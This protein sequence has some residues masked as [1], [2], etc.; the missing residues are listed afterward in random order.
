M[1][2]VYRP[3]QRPVSL[4][5]PRAA[6]THWLMQPHRQIHP[7]E[8]EAAFGGAGGP[9]TAVAEALVGGGGVGADRA[10]VELGVVDGVGLV[11]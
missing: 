11:P 6:L 9:V 3:V 1:W 4:H 5:S 2:L 8:V 10:L 7:H